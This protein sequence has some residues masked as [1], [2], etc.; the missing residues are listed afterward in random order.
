MA[1]GSWQVRVHA[2]GPEGAGDL[3]VPVP[4]IAVRTKRMQAGLGALL[5][6]LLIFLFAGL[7]SIIGASVRDADLPGGGH[8]RPRRRRARA[9]R[10]S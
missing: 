7:V 4:A 6:A 9:S 2:E 1:T 5:L 8:A 3:S 10:S